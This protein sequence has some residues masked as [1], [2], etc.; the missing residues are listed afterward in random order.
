MINSTNTNKKEPQRQD[1]KTLLIEAVTGGLMEKWNNENP[2]KKVANGMR[3]VEVARQ[4]ADPSAPRGCVSK[5]ADARACKEDAEGRRRQQSQPPQE[6]CRSCPPQEARAA[7]I[8]TDQQ[9]TAD[10]R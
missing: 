9:T 5:V 7:V 8:N 6:T 4:N 1:G 10:G 2:S 3:I